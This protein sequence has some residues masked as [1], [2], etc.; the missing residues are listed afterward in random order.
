MKSRKKTGSIFGKAVVISLVSLIVLSIITI[1]IFLYNYDLKA[2]KPYLS[3]LVEDATGRK[4]IIGGNIH[5]RVSLA[6]RVIIEDIAL[7]NATWGSKENMIHASRIKLQVALIPLFFNKIIFKQLVISRPDIL[8]EIGPD[9]KSNFA[10][11]TDSAEDTDEDDTEENSWP[12]FGSKKIILEYGKFTLNDLRTNEAYLAD[13]KRLSISGK[14]I[15]KPV[16][17]QLRGIYNQQTVTADGIVG[18]LPALSNPDE[19]FLLNLLIKSSGNAISLNGSVNDIASMNGVH[20]D[21]TSKINSSSAFEKLTRKPFPIQTPFKLSGKFT[22]PEPASY[23]IPEFSISAPDIDVE[24]SIRLALKDKQP[25]LYA[26]IDAKALDLIPFMQNP[27]ET[28]NKNTS[29]KIRDKNKENTKVF[30]PS[31]FPEINF[32]ALDANVQLKA[33]SVRFPG[34]VFDTLSADIKLTDGRFFINDYTCGMGTGTM[35]GYFHLTPEK[36]RWF[37]ETALK[38]EQLPLERLVSSK[39]V[40]DSLEGD[41]DMLFFLKGHGRSVAEIMSNLEG[42]VGLSMCDGIIATKYIDFLG[43]DFSSSLLKRINPF[44]K[45]AKHTEVNCFVCILNIYD[46]VAKT[47]ALVLDTGRTL[48]FG[49]GRVYFKSEKISIALKPVPKKGIGIK[50]IGKFS[51]SLTELYKPVKIS[52]TLAEPSLAIDLTQT[53][54]TLSKVAGGVALLGPAGAALA[55]ITGRFGDSNPCLSAV[56]AVKQGTKEKGLTYDNKKGIV[57]KTTKSITDRLKKLFG[58]FIKKP[59]K[60]SAA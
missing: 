15:N 46:G 26:T 58:Y 36:N 5:L 11:E 49:K 52:G 39:K 6:P 29:N 43:A 23:S 56:E 32:K 37:I 13:I 34:I 59:D 38:V 33:A 40:T 60:K 35:D 24:G 41:I 2:V 8:L 44:Q 20:L 57:K 25:M 7:E 16:N 17:L 31:P 14:D 27:D 30:S 1:Y 3:D 48:T 53:A 18:P 54:I 22:K 28:E 42:D 12:V 55:L 9:G 47:E 45:N 21:F 19:T 4:L 10:F 51:I 50:K